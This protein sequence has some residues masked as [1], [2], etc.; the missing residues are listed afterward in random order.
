MVRLLFAAS[1]LWGWVLCATPAFAAVPLTRNLAFDGV[2]DVATVAH[3]TSLA[4]TAQV[5]VEAWVKLNSI[6]TTLNQDRVLAK[7]GSYELTVSSGD[8]GCGFNTQG[9]VQWRATIGGKDGRVCAGQ[10]TFGS[11]YHIAGTHNGSRFILYIDGVPVADVARTGAIATNTSPLFLG[12]R[13]ELNRPFDGALDEVRIWNRAL[14]QVQLQAGMEQTLSGDAAGLLAYY[15]FEEGSGQTFMDLGPQANQ[16]VRGASSATESSDPSWVT[17]G[18]P[19]NQAPQVDAGSDQ[20]VTS[21]DRATSLQGVASDDGLPDGTF[22][23]S[24]FLQS[25]P[26]NAVFQNSDNLNT[27]VSFTTDGLYVLEL[28]VTDGEYTVSDTVRL[29]VQRESV[30]VAL[31]LAPALV[32]LGTGEQQTFSAVGR[33]ATGNSE[34]VT[35]TWSATNGSISTSGVYSPPTVAG[36]YTVTAVFGSLSATATVVATGAPT[37]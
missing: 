14:T 5:T 35:V 11:W 29:Q 17:G 23:A 24:W 22:S 4:P 10:L 34:P 6:S 27:G 2:D 3:H 13:P 1:S 20:T 9:H 36:Q 32:T 33:D 7:V 18:A 25:G 30:V 26:G 19:S 21:Q 37:L 31:E 15:R 16:G 12:N 8:T 28:T